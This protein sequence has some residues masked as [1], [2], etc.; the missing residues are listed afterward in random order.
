VHTRV[1]AL[2]DTLHNEITNQAN[3]WE[4]VFSLRAKEADLHPER[5][6]DIARNQG[7]G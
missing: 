4:N 3:L 7:A 2:R 5:E 6:M 1:L